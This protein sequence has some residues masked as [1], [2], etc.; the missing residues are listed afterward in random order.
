MTPMQAIETATVNAARLM[1]LEEEIGRLD[2]GMPADIVATDQSPL[3]DIK[4]LQNITFVMKG[5]V[6]HLLK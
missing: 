4:A 2:E 1:G 6:T 3:L 5:G